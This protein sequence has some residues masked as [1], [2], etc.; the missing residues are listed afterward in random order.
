M[1]A[2]VTVFLLFCFPGISLAS[3]RISEVAWMGSTTSANDAWIELV[4]SDTSP[5]SLEGWTLSA[6]DGTPHITLSGTISGNGFY[7]LERTDDTTVPTVTA[8]ALFTGVLTNTGEVLTLKDASGSS[9]YSIDASSGWPAGDATTH[10]T[11]QWSGSAWVTGQGTPRAIN[12]ISSTTETE[13]EVPEDTTIDDQ[14][15]SDEEGSSDAV[16]GKQEWE[17]DPDPVYVAS[18]NIPDMTIRGVPTLFESKVTQDKILTTISGRFVWNMGDGTQY[19]LLKNAPIWHTY[20]YPGVYMV[21]FQ[22]Y[23]NH[24]KEKPD[25]IQ[26]KTITVLDTSLVISQVDALGGISLQNTSSKELNIEKWVLEQQG[27]SY[28][29]PQFT[30]IAA[31]KILT[32][33]ATVTKFMPGISVMLKYPRGETIDQYPKLV[34][35]TN[36]YGKRVIKKTSTMPTIP[37]LRTDEKL[38]T[39]DVGIAQT[40]NVLPETKHTSLPVIFITGLV[41]ASLVGYS[42]IVISSNTKQRHESETLHQQTD[43]SLIPKSEEFNIEDILREP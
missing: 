25:M 15:S 31:K 3:V 20:E 34:E 4:N 6:N 36:S 38:E 14:E 2:S 24:F 11:M 33:P 32:I 43:K 8:D 41:L 16:R 10:E 18:A 30:Y 22:Y 28:H 12:I 23:S 13:S 27:V 1:R 39:S 42:L 29:I 5:V 26:K 35:S 19:E 17:I 37:I 40:A 9:V 7:L 21:V